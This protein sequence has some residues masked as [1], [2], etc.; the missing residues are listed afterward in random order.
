MSK[1][2]EETDFEEEYGELVYCIDCKKAFKCHDREYLL[3]N[4]GHDVFCN[5]FV[6]KTE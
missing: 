2:T 4:P 5:D 1:M 3:A 6:S